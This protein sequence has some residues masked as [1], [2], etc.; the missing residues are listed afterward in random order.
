MRISD[1]SSDVCSS[2][3]F[4]HSKDQ[5]HAYFDALGLP[6]ESIHELEV[7][8]D[9]RAHYSKRTVDFEF[10]YPIGMEELAGLAYRTAFDIK[11]I[12]RAAKKSRSE[13]RRVG[14]ECVITCRYRWSPF[15]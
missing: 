10:D 6:K 3:L 1:W 2:N 4:N 12:E 14:Q 9:D 15:H 8:E 11:N 7:P 13:E 5:W